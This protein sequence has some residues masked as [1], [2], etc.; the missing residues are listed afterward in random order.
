MTSVNRWLLLFLRAIPCSYACKHCLFAPQ[1]RFKA[2]VHVEVM[3]AIQAFSSLLEGKATAPYYQNMA[4]YVGDC[5]LNFDGFPQVVS[6]LKTH[7]IEGWQSVAANGFH[8]RPYQEWKAY[9]QALREAGTEVLEFSLYGLPE[10]HDWFAGY[11]GSYEDIQKVAALWYEI[12]GEVLWSI[13]VHKRNLNEVSTL[14]R[15]LQTRYGAEG[16]VVVWDYLGWGAY[17]E[18]LRIEATDLQVLDEASKK[19]LRGLKT[20]GEWIA[21]LQRE[22]ALPF[23]L[24]PGVIQL[25]VEKSGDV[26]MPYT[27]VSSGLE[28]EVIGNVFREPVDEVLNR[29]EKRYAAWAASYPSVGELCRRYGDESNKRLYNK[30][31][32]VRKWSAAFE[33]QSRVGSRP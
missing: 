32:I 26:K 11:P 30:R 21:A 28:G 10:T 15:E 27:T 13:F 9:L 2:M 24:S 19:L 17:S 29:W 5:A 12:G 22:D 3:E 4:V 8:R 20:E 6:F 18:A 31:S 33:A 25:V 1:K 7:H 14:R 16:E 23:G